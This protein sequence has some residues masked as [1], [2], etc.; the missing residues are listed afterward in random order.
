M[1]SNPILVVDDE[2]SYLE[3][4]KGLL[5]DEGYKN[6]LTENNPL[7][8]MPL[9]ERTDVDLILLDVYMPEMNGLDLLE[10]IYAEYPS[11]PVVIVTAVNEVE[12]ALKAVKLGAYEF[13]TKP[14][15]TDRL[16]LT[17]L[18]ALP[19]I[20]LTVKPG[21]SLICVLFDNSSILSLIIIN[22]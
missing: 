5:N 17:I 11:I 1:E 2:S 19:F 15:N 18:R 12:I 8:V 10:K 20:S 13:I 16:L 9:L 7:K 4:V 14:P 22:S 21:L 6:V 3:L